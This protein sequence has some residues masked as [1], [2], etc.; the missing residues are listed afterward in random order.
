VLAALAVTGV[1]AR[2]Q[3]NHGYVLFSGLGL[4]LLGSLAWFFATIIPATLNLRWRP[5]LVKTDN[6]KLFIRGLAGVL[7]ILGLVGAIWA[8][9]ETEGDAQR[10]A[11]SASFDTAKSVLKAKVTADGLGTDQRMSVRVEGLKQIGKTS[12]LDF[13]EPHKPLYFALLGPDADGK[14][15][16]EFSVFVPFRF[17]IVG[18]TAWTAKHRPPCFDRPRRQSKEAGCL[19]VRLMKRKA[20]H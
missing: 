16:Y 12:G 11:V 1:L 3:R 17:T 15:S 9:K 8:V 13:S 19:A 5:H 2:A 18:V 6:L 14:V 10:P 20:P 7:F 4:V